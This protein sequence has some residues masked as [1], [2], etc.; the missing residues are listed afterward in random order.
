MRRTLAGKGLDAGP[1]TIAWH[2]EHHHQLNVSVA[3]IS[4]HLHAAGLIIPTPAKRPKSSYIRFADEQPNER[5]QA[6]FTHWHLANGAHIEILCWVDDHSRYA[7]SVTAHHRITGP[8]VTEEFKKTYA[9]HGIPY[10]TLTDNGMVF[11]TRF[12]GGKGDATA[13]KPNYTT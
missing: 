12:A 13:T 9:R 8:I 3:S 6:D 5:W 11:T 7:L 1:H 2:L 4:R 10:S